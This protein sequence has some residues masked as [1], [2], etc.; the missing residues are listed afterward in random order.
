MSKNKLAVLSRTM[1]KKIKLQILTATLFLFFLNLIK[2]FS[3]FRF[4]DFVY[5]KLKLTLAETKENLYQ[6]D[7]TLN[8]FLSRFI[9][10]QWI[11]FLNYFPLKPENQLRICFRIKNLWSHLFKSKYVEVLG[12]ILRYL[13]TEQLNKN[14]DLLLNSEAPSWRRSVGFYAPRCTPTG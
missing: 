1:T 6:I 13:E 4:R 14:P 11:K 2:F 8:I 7:S 3:S 9:K 5:L 12:G 10:I